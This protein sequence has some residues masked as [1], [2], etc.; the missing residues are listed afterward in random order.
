MDKSS[1]D[2]Y[3]EIHKVLSNAVDLALENG[4]PEDAIKY[5][6]MMAELEKDKVS[7]IEYYDMSSGILREYYNG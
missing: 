6:D 3:T 4:K 1:A 5:A 2:K 7:F